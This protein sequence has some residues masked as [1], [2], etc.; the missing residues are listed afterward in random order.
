MRVK[1]KICFV[2]IA[3]LVV[4]VAV[5]IGVEHFRGHRAWEKW[6]QEKRKGGEP[7]TLAEILPPPV[8]SEKN[9]APALM[10]AAERIN[11][12]LFDQ[13]RP[14]AAKLI[15]PDKAAVSTK[16]SQWPHREKQAEPRDVWPEFAAMVAESEPAL[17]LIY[18]AMERDQ[19]DFALNYNMGSDIPLP[20]L[21]KTKPLVSFLAYHAQNDLH[22]GEP[23]R[24]IKHL[25]L[26]LRFVHMQAPEYL[27][28]SQLVRMAEAYII[29]SV[30]WEGLQQGAWTEPQLASLQQAWEELEFVA[31]MEMSYRVERAM[32]FALFDRMRHS[33]AEAVKFMTADSP[34]AGLG[35]LD[36]DE[37]RV[38][39][40]R[41][42]EL[43]LKG[44]RKVG[45]GLFYAPLWR[46]AWRY[47]DQERFARMYDPLITQLRAWGDGGYMN[48]YKESEVAQSDEARLG[49]PEGRIAQGY[50]HRWRFPVSDILGA[51][52]I[53]PENNLSTAEAVRQMTV[54]AIALERYRRAQGV[55]PD[56]LAELVPAWLSRLPLDP[57]DGDTLRYR[58]SD[59]GGF[60]LYS[61]G[62][63]GKDDQGDATDPELK[64]L[65]RSRDIMR[66][67]GKDLVWPRAA[68][69]EEVLEFLRSNKN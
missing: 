62:R 3:A 4:V 41:M 35:S 52:V 61:V 51:Y 14:E 57:M 54:T 65:P 30:C 59:D 18:E 27:I 33:N 1:R 23:E 42:V 24:A 10:T 5:L 16:M 28:M 6:L 17:K 37:T 15:A 58:K 20:H 39:M 45:T 68:S 50:Y 31:P 67:R 48:A 49:S 44:T 40:R 63:D 36:T 7:I 38:T 47:Q 22:R 53:S 55:W 46:M 32:G 11:S 64:R 19:L 13:P 2:M 69:E 12:K 60:L 8:P 26:A 66:W 43:A 56:E 34:A 9:A 29:W 21:S 25:E